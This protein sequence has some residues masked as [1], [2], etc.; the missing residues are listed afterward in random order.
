[1][2]TW[3]FFT[4]VGVYEN[5]YW[6]AVGDE[7]GA[8]WTNQSA[9]E[10]LVGVKVFVQK[11]VDEGRYRLDIYGRDSSVPGGLSYGLINGQTVFHRVYSLASGSVYDAWPSLEFDWNGNPPPLV[12]HD[13]AV[14]APEP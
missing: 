12:R 2:A 13:L 5:N 1:M 4:D 11:D 6:P 8:F 7:I 14:S 3:G 10:I 9:V